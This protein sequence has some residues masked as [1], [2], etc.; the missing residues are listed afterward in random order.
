MTLSV[1]RFRSACLTIGGAALA[2]ACAA[3]GA[4]AQAV[5]SLYMPRSI[6]KT[7]A[8]HTRLMDGRPGPAYWEN[9]AR[10]TMTVSA[11]PPDRTIHGSE[12][13]V[14]MNNSPDTLRALIIRLF[15]NVHRPGAPRAGGTGEDYLTPGVQIDTFAVNGTP[16]PWQNSARFFTWQPVRLGTPLAPHDSVTLSF[17]WHYE[18][19]KRAGREGMLDSTTYYLAYFYPRVSVY[20]D[21]NGW[22]T[23]DFTDE[24]E[25]YSDFNDYDVT[26]DVPANYVVWGTGTLV[27]P[28]AD[29]QPA[30]LE[31]FQ[32]SFTSDTTV[33]VATGAD[34]AAGKITTQQPVNHW[35]FTAH[36]VPDMAFAVSNHY[37]WDAASVLVDD[38]AHRRASVQAA[39]ND[40]AADYHHMVDFAHHSL[41]WLSHN[42]PGVPYP[43]E[44]STIVQGS[45][46]MEYP[47]MVNDGSTPD[48]IF[49]RFVVE[50]EIAHTYFP[51]YMG[52]N[53]SRY[54]FMD[55]GWATTFENLIGTSDLGAARATAFFKQFRVTQWIHDPSPLE[56][57]PIVTP[58]DVLKGVAY[59]N[60]AYGKPALG[61]LAL[62]RMLGD[63]TFRKCL[64]AF[65]DRW[66]GKHPTPWDLFYTFNDASGQ[67]LDWFWKSWFFSNGYI[68]L[69]I[70]G[71][72]RGAKGYAVALDNI[73]GFPAPVDLLVQYSDA[74]VDTVHETSAIWRANLHHTTVT[75][76]ARKA[77]ASIA[78]D[79]GIWM[80]A[81]TTNDRWTV[82][83]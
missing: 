60:N 71:A 12:Q 33:H 27:D 5:T 77:I 67:N 73:G 59:G 63:D 14:Y 65:M 51:F 45:A 1:R 9:H 44:K 4:G 35:H 21:Y 64:H 28:S 32:S 48:T 25:F 36:N 38:T 75:V 69:A 78:L 72:H 54:A 56:D 62:K 13:I 68:D 7:Y 79:H 29:L 23:M 61:Y 46:D 53:E 17:D 81:D 15:L 83:R 52:I 82:R 34:L 66:H 49:S 6:K 50:H 19:S 2:V 22:D 40:T 76:P 20:D 58:E 74:S 10:Y 16:T 42:W 31:R 39:Y 43:Y 80:D 18:I 70:T 8:E 55:E 30:A 41:D 24:Q 57:L 11:M 26:L 37:D 3:P 47:M